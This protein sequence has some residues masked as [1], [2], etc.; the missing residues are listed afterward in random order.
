MKK[1]FLALTIAATMT[2]SA[3][4]FARDNSGQQGPPPGGERRGPGRGMNADAMLQRMSE[5]LNLTD[6]QKSKIKPILQDSEK[7]MKE[8]RDN[9]SVSDD[10]RRTKMMEIRKSSNE[11]INPVLT[12]DQ[13]K[14]WAEERERRGGPERGP[15]NGGPGGDQKPQ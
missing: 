8:L 7:Q 12:P 14:K 3:G 1:L 6:D 15:G 11:K 9:T 13:Q 2:L 10:D 4:A 5:S